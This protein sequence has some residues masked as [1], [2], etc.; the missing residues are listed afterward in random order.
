MT[1][2][3][4]GLIFGNKGPMDQDMLIH[5]IYFFLSIGILAIIIYKFIIFNIER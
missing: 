4:A 3:L 1:P 5:K 2:Q